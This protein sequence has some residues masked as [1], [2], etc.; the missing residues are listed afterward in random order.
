MVYISV[1]LEEFGF[2]PH[3]QFKVRNTTV[4]TRAWTRVWSEV[5]SLAMCLIRTWPPLSVCCSWRGPSTRWQP[6]GLWEQLFSILCP[7]RDTD[8]FIVKNL[9]TQTS[10]MLWGDPGPPGDP[11]HKPWPQMMSHLWSDHFTAQC[12]LLLLILE[13]HVTVNTLI[14]VHCS[15]KTSH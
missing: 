3:K 12:V 14:L 4:W 15:T 7:C 9:T 6:V 8:A 13:V 2:S 1:L 10:W 5:W 11:E